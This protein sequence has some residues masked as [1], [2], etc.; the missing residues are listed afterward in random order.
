[1][2]CD[3][4]IYCYFRGKGKRKAQTPISGNP[5]DSYFKK[6]RNEGSKTSDDNTAKDPKLIH[7]TPSTPK[8]DSSTISDATSSDSSDPENKNTADSDSG[9]PATTDKPAFV[10]S[11]KDEPRYVPPRDFVFP[12]TRFG[13]D[14][15]HCDHHWFKQYDWLEYNPDKGAVFCKTC[16]HFVVQVRIEHIMLVSELLNIHSFL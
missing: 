10:F 8:T 4:I 2:Q 13:K 7:S 3:A 1:M 11:T 12:S 6:P 16:R 14:M 15:R 9:I 5:I